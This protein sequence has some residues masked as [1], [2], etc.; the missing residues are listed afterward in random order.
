MRFGA[1]TWRFPA[2]SSQVAFWW[3]RCDMHGDVS[4]AVRRRA[5]QVRRAWRVAANHAFRRRRAHEIWC[6]KVAFHVFVQFLGMHSATNRIQ[7]HR[8]GKCLWDK[9][10]VGYLCRLES[11]KSQ[12]LK[13]CGG[14]FEHKSSEINQYNREFAQ[15]SGAYC[16]TNTHMMVVVVWHNMREVPVWT[17]IRQR[18]VIEGLW[19]KLRGYK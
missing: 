14:S 17:W 5:S 12:W 8:W 2:R 11:G 1:F 18:S 16:F 10:C 7:I 19:R 6:F 4:W 15:F 9:I 3:P 13:H